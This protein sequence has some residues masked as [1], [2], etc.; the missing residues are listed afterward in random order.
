MNARDLFASMR[1]DVWFFDLDGA[2]YSNTRIVDKLL[3]QRYYELTAELYRIAIETAPMRLEVL[4]ERHETRLMRVALARDGVPMALIAERTQ[5]GVIDLA[6]LGLAPPEKRIETITA[7]RGAR[8]VLTDSPGIYARAMLKA[9]ELNELFWDVIAAEDMDCGLASKPEPA[10]IRKVEDALRSG[11]HV[12]FVD[13]QLHI[14]QAV[15]ELPGRITTVLVSKH[16]GQQ[17]AAPHYWVES[18]DE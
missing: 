15:A 16:R 10:A 11:A 12:V 2:L 3:R 6:A 7:A 4:K 5:L 18:L 8:Y 17:Q 13:D 1:A 14:V 9:L